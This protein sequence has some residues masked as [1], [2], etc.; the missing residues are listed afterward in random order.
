MNEQALKSNAI[1]RI[2]QMGKVGLIISRIFFVIMCI[3]VAGILL[4][5][6][7]V[8]VLPDEFLRFGMDGEAWMEVDLPKV[9]METEGNTEEMAADL[10]KS[11]EN[12]TLKGSIVM[13]NVGFQVSSVEQTSK[14]FRF[15]GTGSYNGF[16]RHL[17]AVMVMAL[18]YAV[19]VAVVLLFV[20]SLCKAFRDCAS[21]FEDNVIRKMQH[22]AFSLL[23][24]AAYA[25][26]AGVVSVNLVGSSVSLGDGDVKLGVDPAIL[27]TSLIIFALAYVFKYGAVLQRESDETL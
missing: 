6:V 14:G 7:V 22:L 21:P 15:F 24:W 23:A 9:L 12:G 19:I 2:R 26:V 18:I 10:Q 27:I 4:V 5:T 8:A 13:G 11:L 20:C 1:Q 16:V 17:T 3:G 25:F